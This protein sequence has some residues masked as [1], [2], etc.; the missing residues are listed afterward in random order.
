M[1][2]E[3]WGI[4]VITATTVIEMDIGEKYSWDEAI[5]TETGEILK[6]KRVTSQK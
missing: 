1:G 4:G 5:S 3:G 2:K 6:E